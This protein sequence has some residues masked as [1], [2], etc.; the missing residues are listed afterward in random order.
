V[1]NS[2]PVCIPIFGWLNTNLLSYY[3][4]TGSEFV[5]LACLFNVPDLSVLKNIRPDI[6]TQE[7]VNDI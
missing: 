7:G 4:M 1:D 2:D 5:N 3:E 6:F